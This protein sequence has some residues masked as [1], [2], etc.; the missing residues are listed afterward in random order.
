MRI[1]YPAKEQNK[2][3]TRILTK[4]MGGGFADA[5]CL[6]VIDN[7]DEIAGIVAYFNYRHPNIEVGFFCD[8]F[9][10]A[11]NRDGVIEVLSYPFVQ[12]NCCRITA[13]VEKKN[14]RARKMVQRLGFVEEGKLR[15]AGPKGDILI[16]GL[17]ADE[18]KLRKYCGKHTYATACA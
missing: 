1:C 2:E 8:D 9:R 10:W 4:R 5:Q 15:K 16:Y 11:L 13:C 6:A 3:L 17:L 12:L 18:L 7:D 14:F